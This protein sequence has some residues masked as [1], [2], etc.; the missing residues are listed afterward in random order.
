MPD[1]S[2]QNELLSLS[3]Q[4]LTELVRKLGHPAFRG[5]QVADAIFRHRQESLSGVSNLPSAL[6]SQISQHGLSVGFPR[7]D[8]KFTSVDG[9]VRY[10]I[11]FA[12]EQSVET[13][14]MPEG[15][16]GEAGDGTEA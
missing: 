5:R 7:I 4:E 16:N 15:D 9:T 13:V 12:D 10:L 11:A 6:K 8:Q 1:M 14:W 3:N 2:V